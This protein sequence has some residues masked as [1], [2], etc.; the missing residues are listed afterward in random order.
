MPPRTTDLTGGGPP[1]RPACQG[2]P[3]E[4][5][6][7][8]FHTV[9]L[10]L[11]LTL[12][13]G[14]YWPIVNNFFHADDFFHLYN[15]VSNGPLHF[16]LT[17]HGGHVLVVRNLIFSACYWLFGL[18]PQGYFV[19]VLVT[20]LANVCLLFLVIRRFTGDAVLACF[21]ATLW[22][23]SP[24]N[25]GALGW[26]SVYGQVLVATIVLWLLYDV[27]R[28]SAG[29]V[30]PSVAR[31]MAWYLL[32]L[33]AST[34][35]GIGAAVAVTFAVVAYLLLPSSAQRGS[36]AVM[37]ASLVLVVPALYVMC[38][39][40]EAGPSGLNGPGSWVAAAAN[41]WRACAEMFR[42][43]LTHAIDTLALPY[44]CETP[45]GSGL[46]Y[47]FALVVVA[48]LLV[49][50]VW[51]SAETKR[52]IAALTLV[53]CS[54]YASIAVGRGPMVVELAKTAQWGA[55]TPRYHYFGP[56]VLAVIFCVL[57]YQLV[58]HN[59]RWAWGGRAIASCWLVGALAASLHHGRVVN[60]H[61]ASR[62]ETLAVL[63]MVDSFSRATPQGQEACIHNQHFRSAGW[64][65]N[66]NM[67]FPGWAAVFAIAH[68]DRVVNG[69][70]VRF[71]EPDPRTLA[72]AQ[73]SPRE[74][75]AS[76]LVAPN[77]LPPHCRVF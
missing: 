65:G 66:G 46:R 19:L 30:L 36:I 24:A 70:T 56:A 63:Q 35:F 32:L 31:R 14:A 77:Q 52:R 47:D 57:L 59:V 22:G 71:I 58:G 50:V 43:L 34:C 18:A 11:A 10:A 55:Q 23:V 54:S 5:T 53:L 6:Q 37:L 40:V 67:F 61:D 33:A 7:R 75:I 20:H 72:V 45:G 16:F 74:R 69:R 76:L 26:Y 64:L 27:M 17:P 28:V 21:G 25:E 49:C 39:R 48:A 44:C 9:L 68:P 29:Q 42:D 62:A 3:S 13:A 2:P 38:H 12:S 51:S 73:A 8:K 15:L 41:N 60:H 4:K 1:N